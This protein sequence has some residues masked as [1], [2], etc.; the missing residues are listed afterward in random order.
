MKPFP[1]SIFIACV[2]VAPMQ[3][4]YV[5]TAPPSKAP[6]SSVRFEKKRLTPQYW[7]EG[8]SVA[9]LNRDGH[10]DIVCGGHYYPGPAFNQRHEFTT[11]VPANK[12]GPY[13]GSVY[14]LEDFFSWTHDFNQDGSMDIMVV[15]LTGRP[16][17]WFENPGRFPDAKKQEVIHW[18]RHELL[19]N[20]YLETVVFDDLLGEG[21][22]QFVCA[23]K[24]Q[25]GYARPDA[26][27]PTKPWSFTPISPPGDF[28]S[29]GQ[30]HSLGIGDVDG[31]GRQDILRKDGWWRQPTEK[32]VLWEFNRFEFA[33]MGGGE[34]YAYDVNGDGLNDII[35]AL[36]AHAWGLSWFEQTRDSQGKISF[37]EHPI[38]AAEEH[39]KAN[40][41]GV[42]F[43]QL[44][45]LALVD[46]D[47][48]GLLDLV[49][50]KTWLAHDYG[51]PG[52]DQP[53]VL[54]WFKLTRNGRETEF[55]PHLIDNDSGIG[56]RI[57]TIDLNKDGRIDIVIGSKKGLF[58]FTQTSQNDKPPK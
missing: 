47:A 39:G 48:D 6:A 18:K 41:F 26:N 45:A 12:R 43:S 56:R 13:D 28:T 52:L 11:P 5:P 16:T 54:Y 19:P 7:S 40:R 15:G 36:H 38:L 20:V 51:D 22:P 30:A 42:Q 34:M 27:D 8:A 49:T 31:D 55:I 37:K 50:G 3:A 10:L 46:V 58:V 1:F 23:H 35:T 29:Y 21:K 33:K 25:L 17:A 9:D 44:H 4:Q 14:T 32:G 57:I 53:A 24:K 2:C